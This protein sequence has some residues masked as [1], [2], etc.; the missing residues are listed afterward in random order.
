MALVAVKL[1]GLYS[2]FLCG[3]VGGAG[4]AYAE[5]HGN[6]L[7]VGWRKLFDFEIPGML[8]DADCV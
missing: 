2:V 7:D 5:K 1:A 3:I 8:E 4:F 6:A